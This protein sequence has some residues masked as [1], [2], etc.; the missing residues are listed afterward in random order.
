MTGLLS[1]PCLPGVHGSQTPRIGRVV[2]GSG[3]SL[4]INNQAR[5]GRDGV[6]PGS[7]VDE[8]DP[9]RRR[10]E[11]MEDGLKDPAS[12]TGIADVLE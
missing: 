2:R 7:S 6:C 9:R 5:S 3:G 11:G 4:P 8:R 10:K 1:H 12:M